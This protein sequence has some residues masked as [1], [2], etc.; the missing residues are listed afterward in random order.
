MKV[1]LLCLLFG[2]SFLRVQAQEG[3]LLNA[4][5]EIAERSESELEEGD[6]FLMD[7][8]ELFSSRINLNTVS[9]IDLRKFPGITEIQLAAFFEY[10]NIFGPLVS[11]YELQAVPY[12]DAVLCRKIRPYIT[13]GNRDRQEP[14]FA[15]RLKDGEYTGLIRMSAEAVASTD[16]K[17]LGD[18]HK[19]LMRFRYQFGQFMQWGIVAEK[20]AG[21]PIFKSPNHYGFDFYSIHFFIRRYK[22]IR[23][24]AL[25]DYRVNLGQGLL[26]WQSQS[27]GMGAEV[28]Q[29]KRQEDVLK[30][31]QSQRE[32]GF[33]RGVGITL[34][35][36]AKQISLFIS[37][38]DVDALVG[39]DSSAKQYITSFQNSGVHR[40]ATEI[41]N[42]NS[43]QQTTVG[44][45]IGYSKPRF[46]VGING[47]YS[48]YSLPIQKADK[49]YN[50][51]SFNGSTL[52]QTS[53]DYAYTRRN[54]HLFG[55]AALSGGGAILTGAMVNLVPAADLALVY[56]NYS[57]GFKTLMGDAF[58]VGL[59]P[60]NEHGL[61]VGL[62]L[63]FHPLVLFSLY[64]DHYLNPF[65][66]FR[67]SGIGRGVGY[68]AVLRYTPAKRNLLELRYAYKKTLQNEKVSDA[69]PINAFMV[70]HAMRMH[71][72]FPI[73]N[74]SDGTCRIEW[75]SVMGGS[76]GYLMYGDFKKRFSRGLNMGLRIQFSGIDDFNNRIYVYEP[77]VKYAGSVVM[78]NHSGIRLLLNTTKVI[79][80]RFTVSAACSMRTGATRS[81]Y[82]PFHI[83][84]LYYSIQLVYKR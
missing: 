60:V 36:K 5:E 53:V 69:M 32:Y 51:F 58:G 43:V 64:A 11:I 71:V 13:V 42:K 70:K 57:P 19:L 25:G 81:N 45:N 31:H 24:L 26:V 55:E 10:R 59:Q 61:Y 68:L 18:K 6:E 34:G 77:D 21:E 41:K 83:E 14:G 29:V 63:K 2:V 22:F 33:M 30:P 23:S 62:Q 72:Q 78:T 35:R 3:V 39:L 47:L 54:V 82:A 75:N 12:W 44:L 76:S 52:F 84:S 66:K 73:G 80:R 37:H 8:E 16:E 46:H 40:M 15:A 65:F 38:K 4:L 74:R 27:F 20:D 7:T 67:L 50:R 1:I 9:E 28:L 48:H 56:R 79:R 49:V 17:W